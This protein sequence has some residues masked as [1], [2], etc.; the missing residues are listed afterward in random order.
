MENFLLITK[1]SL[2]LLLFAF[3]LNQS[4]AQNQSFGGGIGL[5]SLF[6]NG[7]NLKQNAG[8][9]L[10]LPSNTQK[11]FS[12]PQLSLSI[13]YN[14][15]NKLSNNWLG[16][17]YNPIFASSHL[18][19]RGQVMYN[20]FR[21]TPEKNN[22]IVSFGGSLL[23]FPIVHDATK[24]FNF[25]VEAGYKAAWNN[26]AFDPF[27][28]LVLGAGTRHNLSNDWILQTNVNYTLAFNDYIDQYGF[29]G[30]AVKNSDGYALF[31][32]SF[33]KPFFNGTQ[34]KALDSA[35][36]SLGMARSFAVQAIQKGH[37]VTE[38]VKSIQ[39]LVKP[40][41]E[42]IQ[43]DKALALKISETAFGVSDKAISVRLNLQKGKALDKAEREM[44]SLK[45]VISML[46]ITRLLDYEWSNDIH[47]I[48][49]DVAKKVQEL[50][51]D[52]QDT[53]QNLKFAFQFL[54]LLKDLE[55]EA[56]RI[57]VKE[58]A[59]ARMVIS[60]AEQAIL[61]GQ[62]DFETA[63]NS[64]REIK[65]SFERADK[66]VKIALEDIEKTE[67]EIAAFRK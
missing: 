61:V 19:L 60:K 17:F 37:H 33:L 55:E 38:N 1:K 58:G 27:N 25:F 14:F 26:A 30:F 22:S 4:N 48:E 18:Q 43:E 24:N 63:H 57:N 2:F 50:Q 34:K 46:N 23:Y 12:K 42:K 21:I 31:N 6:S 65:N 3:F 20:Q 28:C 56:Q 54:P 10:G 49:R 8:Y 29:K 39:K 7:V 16:R 51:R 36:D 45:T 66:N 62:K 9:R 40:L 47:L 15:P 11:A 13:D 64:L 67:K 52:V 35:K 53:R 41:L 32:V 44:D 59:E 5:N